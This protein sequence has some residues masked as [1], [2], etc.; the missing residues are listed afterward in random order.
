MPYIESERRKVYDPAIN[1]IVDEMLIADDDD[2]VKGELN[3]CIY[4]II[5]K[6][7]GMRG[8]KYFRLQ[9]FIFGVLGACQNELA[10][11]MLNPYEE[12]KIMD[13]GDVK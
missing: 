3:Y 10:R 8:H 11:R 4:K 7:M 5:L 2:Q 13:N 1:L 9:D 12:K 6:Y